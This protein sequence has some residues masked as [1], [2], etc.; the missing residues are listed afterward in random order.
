[1]ARS[2]WC[3]HCDREYTTEEYSRHVRKV[4]SRMAGR[5]DDLPEFL[6]EWIAEQ[7]DG[8]NTQMDDSE[9]SG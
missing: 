8:T 6:E 3:Y 1:M 5:S 7:T 9:V 4:V 2:N